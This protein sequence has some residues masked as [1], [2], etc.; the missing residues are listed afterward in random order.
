MQE[1]GQCQ[2]LQQEL[3]LKNA[4]LASFEEARKKD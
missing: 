3:E 2:D 4:Q 1:T